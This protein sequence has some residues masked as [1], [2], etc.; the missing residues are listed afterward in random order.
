[1]LHTQGWRSSCALKTSE[2]RLGDREL[3]LILA[4]ELTLAHAVS[5]ATLLPMAG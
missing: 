4:I 3:R 1:M 5:F 2:I